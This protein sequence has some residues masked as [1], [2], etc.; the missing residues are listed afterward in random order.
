ML[1]F[2]I[3]HLLVLLLI[4]LLIEMMIST[5]LI[6]GRIFPTD[7]LLVKKLRSIAFPSE[8]THGAESL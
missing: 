6:G 7:I 8:T 1:E 3:N 4:S 2:K 5:S